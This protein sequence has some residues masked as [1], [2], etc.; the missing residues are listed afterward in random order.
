MYLMFIVIIIIILLIEVN[1]NHF[2]PLRI[3]VGGAKWWMVVEEEFEND[4]HDHL[5]MIHM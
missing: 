5:M 1:L 3:D 2:H 4:G